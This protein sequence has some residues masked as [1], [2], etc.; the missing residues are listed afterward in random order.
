MLVHNQ[1]IKE[2]APA[3]YLIIEKEHALLEKFLSE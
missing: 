3:D 1:A 2:L